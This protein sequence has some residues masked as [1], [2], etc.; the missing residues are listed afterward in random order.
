MGLAQN[1]PHPWV[2]VMGA[3]ALTSPSTPFV[4]K[5]WSSHFLAHDTQA[6]YNEEVYSGGNEE[7]VRVH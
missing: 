5:F 2:C 6:N 1:G 4:I 7:E 3:V